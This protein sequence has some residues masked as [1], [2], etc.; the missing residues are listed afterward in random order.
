MASKSKA[1]ASIKRG[2]V[3]VEA[4]WTLGDVVAA[5]AIPSGMLIANLD[6]PL[7]GPADVVGIPMTLAGLAYFGIKATEK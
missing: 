2:G 6:S 1:R 4:E 5:L 7:P 3:N